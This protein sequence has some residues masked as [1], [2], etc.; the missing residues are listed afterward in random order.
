MENTHPINSTLR[1]PPGPAGHPL[2]GVSG[3]FSGGPLQV[4]AAWEKQY[5]TAVRFR[6]L[7]YIYGYLFT[8]PEHNRHILQENNQNYT[9]QHPSLLILRS[10]IGNGLLT[11]D[12]EF[13]LR[14]RRLS[15]PAFHRARIAG[16]AEMMSAASQDLLRRWLQIP[17]GQ[18]IDVD[19]AMM[20]LTLEIVGK[21]LFSIDLTGAASTVGEAFTY[22]N[23]YLAHMSAVPFGLYR[24]K[25][26]TRGN[27]RLREANRALDQVVHRIIAERRSGASHGD[28]L[29]AMLM[30]ARDEDTG[31]K[32]DDRQLR[33]E[34]MT[35]M[36]AGHETTANA[37][38]WAWYLL[39]RHPQ[40]EDRLHAEL[41]Q[42]LGGRAASI[43][44]LPSLP[45]TRMV[46]DEVLRLYPPAFAIGRLNLRADQVGDYDLPPRSVVTLSPFLTHRSP[47]FWPDPL[48]FDPERF[49]TEQTAH[50][51]RWTYLPFGGGPRQCIGRDFALAEAAIILATLAQHTRLRMAHDS[52]VEIEPLITL[53]PKGGMPMRL[54]ARR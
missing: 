13:W 10:V 32:M 49:S 21:A 14:Q 38:T 51:L 7:P 52:E 29:L 28:D 16:F 17:A 54:L 26:P 45:Y 1:H 3:D 23:Q 27:F 8:H 36:L 47:E 46:I 22:A 39:S 24:L 12:G 18:V 5:G 43:D 41:D 37:L 33:D 42:V 40:V 19:H 6:F 48:R 44:D 4:L 30:T 2:F 31:E 11:S 15:Q 50:R 25:L 9:K 34:V 20:N 53:R 35:L